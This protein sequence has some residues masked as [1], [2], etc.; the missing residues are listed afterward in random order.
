MQPSDAGQ[1]HSYNNGGHC[2]H[3]GA[4]LSPSEA[5]NAHGLASDLAGT[6]SGV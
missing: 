4:A 2:H 6:G 3:S 1:N 5:N